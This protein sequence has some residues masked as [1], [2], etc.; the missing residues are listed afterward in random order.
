MLPAPRRFVIN[1]RAANKVARNNA[2]TRRFFR[3]GRFN[4]ISPAPG[5]NF[6]FVEV[7]S[8][9]NNRREAKRLTNALNRIKNNNGNKKYLYNTISLATRKN[10]FTN[11]VNA[12]YNAMVSNRMRTRT[13]SP[14]SRR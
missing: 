2:T 11:L 4:V 13:P 10:A 7:G 14:P 8:S 12:A 5:V 6:Y 1:K 3:P 9:T